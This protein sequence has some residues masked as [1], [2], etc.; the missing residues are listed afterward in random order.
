M[1][2]ERDEPAVPGASPAGQQVESGLGSFRDRSG[3]LKSGVGMTTIENILIIGAALV[4]LLAVL[5]YW[6]GLFERMQ[7]KI[8]EIFN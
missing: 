7:A 1:S 8:D 4:I 6:P 2:V 5:A 3:R